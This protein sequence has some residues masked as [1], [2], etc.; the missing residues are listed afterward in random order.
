[1]SAADWKR[2]WTEEQTKVY[3]RMSS[4]SVKDLWV[5]SNETPVRERITRMSDRCIQHHRL[6]D[7][8]DVKIALAPSHAE[9]VCNQGN[10]DA[11][12]EC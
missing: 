2:A 6:T 11:R 12:Q 4:C 10:H 5:L 1:M 9:M 3:L 8:N 7:P